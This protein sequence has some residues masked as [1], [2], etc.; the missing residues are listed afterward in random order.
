MI[1]CLQ[2]ENHAFYRFHRLKNYNHGLVDDF[3]KWVQNQSI[4]LDNNEIVEK[5]LRFHVEPID[6]AHN[7]TIILSMLAISMLA[8][9][10][11]CG[12]VF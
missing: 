4:L 6:I 2:Y 7:H 9:R 3:K 5:E 8:N 1:K 11:Y 12:T 10:C